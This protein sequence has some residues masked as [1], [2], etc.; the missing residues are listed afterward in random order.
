MKQI[1]VEQH[2]HTIAFSSHSEGCC[3]AHQSPVVIYDQN[4]INQLYAK[5]ILRKHGMFVAVVYTTIVSLLEIVCL[6]H[7]IENKFKSV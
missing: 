1:K 4:K 5:L 6:Y 7:N 3:C 2:A